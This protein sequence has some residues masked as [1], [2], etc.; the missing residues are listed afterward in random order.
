[1]QGS[2]MCVRAGVIFRLRTIVLG[3]GLALAGAGCSGGGPPP[4]VDED[5]A[6][7]SFEQF[8]TA[9]QSGQ[10]P[11]ALKSLSP[12]IIGVDFEWTAGRKLK[13]FKLLDNGVSDG[14]NLRFSVELEL[15]GK[16][17]RTE[18]RAA[19]YIVGTS[20]VITVFRPT[21]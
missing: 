5:L 20:P 15:T 19:E 7:K 2:E 13:S 16:G 6:R 11:E 3:A 21:D 18:K 8:L 9:W 14:S 10:G 12:Q 4:A 17:S 1:M